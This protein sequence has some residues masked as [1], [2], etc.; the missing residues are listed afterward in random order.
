[1]HAPLEVPF[2]DPETEFIS[3]VVEKYLHL[4]QR[5]LFLSPRDWVV[6]SCWLLWGYDID[7]VLKGLDIAFADV[8]EDSARIRDLSYTS[9][10]V[11]RLMRERR[12][13][14]VGMS[15]DILQKPQ[16]AQGQ[17]DLSKAFE[18]I[19]RKLSTFGR[20]NPWAEGLTEKAQEY[21]SRMEL[22]LF[23]GELDMETALTR[24]ARRE[25]RF[26]SDIFKKLPQDEREKLDGRALKSIEP[27]RGRMS[28]D[29]V[30]R[31]HRAVLRS[32][33]IR[34]KGLPRISLF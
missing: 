25:D 8:E 14:Q 28:E 20:K 26:F 9:R 21:V 3:R 22:K 32:L 17:A 13:M 12:I 15:E 2:E 7:L 6:L 30:K 16:S 24:L 4:R 1:M 5:G 11:E 33:L 29:A 31:T 27:H 23:S 10:V 18:R 34:E 19:R